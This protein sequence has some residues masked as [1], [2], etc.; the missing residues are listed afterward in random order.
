[1]PKK[2]TLPSIKE[3]TLSYLD[4]ERVSQSSQGK[5]SRE[6]SLVSGRAVSRRWATTCAPSS[7]TSCVKYWGALSL[8]NDIRGS[9]RG[10]PNKMKSIVHFTMKNKTDEGGGS[11]NC[12]NIS[13]CSVSC[14]NPSEP[15]WSGRG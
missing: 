1:M 3:D 9:M 4:E 11:F 14:A 5:A 13:T 2:A 12:V 15:R 8:T 6:D 7:A 10:G